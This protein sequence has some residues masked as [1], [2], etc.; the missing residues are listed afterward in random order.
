MLGIGEE[1]S[2]N[3]EG[4]SKGEVVLKIDQDGD[5]SVSIGG[6]GSG[7]VCGLVDRLKVCSLI[8]RDRSVRS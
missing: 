8:W 2:L 7:G 4:L 5:N 6:V 3:A 1:W